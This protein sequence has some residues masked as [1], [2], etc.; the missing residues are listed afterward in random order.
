M[1]K[2]KKF[3]VF[4]IAIIITTAPFS[5]FS[6]KLEDLPLDKETMETVM[7]MLPDYS[8]TLS[9]GSQKD[10]IEAQRKFKKVLA[11]NNLSMEDFQV[12]AN[13]IFSS[14]SFLQMQQQGAAQ[15]F[16]LNSL[17]A[18]M[19]EGAQDEMNLIQEYMPQLQEIMKEFLP[20][21]Q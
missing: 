9:Q 10:L 1:Q 14:F 7:Q 17:T 16:D 11:E 18:M 15:G 13:R 20:D 8:A 4:F 19:P 6:Q 2:I 3:L 5:S 21:E 12:L